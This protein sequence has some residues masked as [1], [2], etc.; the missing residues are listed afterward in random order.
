MPPAI[1][2]IILPNTNVKLYDCTLKFRKVVQQHIW[3]VMVIL[4]ISSVVHLR[5]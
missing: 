2:Q 3:G 1:K 5:I 4:I